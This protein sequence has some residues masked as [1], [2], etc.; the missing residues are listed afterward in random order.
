M[1]QSAR[2]DNAL[3]R[4]KVGWTWLFPI[5][6]LSLACQLVSLPGLD[7]A[8]ARLLGTKSGLIAYIGLDGNVYTIDQDGGNRMAITTDAKLPVGDDVPTRFYRYPTWSP[9]GNRLAFVGLEGADNRGH[10]VGLYTAALNGQTPLEIYRSQEELPFYLYWSP[11]S[12]RVSYL[13]T[14]TGGDLAL[15]VTPA[16]GGETRQLALG[17]PFYWAW[18][19]DNHAILIHTGG[20]AR[21]SQKA[22]LTLLT[23]GESIEEQEL[24]L[25]P[26]FFQAPAWSPA[27]DELLLGG[28]G[29]KGEDS[30]MLAGSDGI[31]KKSL[32]RIDGLIAFG[33]SP[34]GKRVAYVNRGPIPLQGSSDNLLT[35][36]DPAN[37]E[38]VIQMDERYVIAFFWSP[39]SRKLAYLASEVAVPGPQTSLPGQA[40]VVLMLK[41]FVLDLETGLSRQ[42]ATFQPT[43]DFTSVLPYFDQY[44]HSATLWSPDS[45]CLVIAAENTGAP[46]GIYIL[47]TA[48]EGELGWIADGSLAFWS[49]K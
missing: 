7:N 12:Q 29:E 19:P 38:A 42:L 31:V 37:P 11:D 21:Y 47:N 22:R 35:I 27:G 3:A 43:A 5:V 6:F 20:A 45:C 18:A 2:V 9:D 40:D 49:W 28:I 15:K 17:A 1:N 39:D 30:L 48:D 46:P 33:W 4:Y 44:Q 32:G 13:T 10:A 14:A 8:A 26:S 36:L 23:L 24:A 25:K 16:T 41:L 34:D